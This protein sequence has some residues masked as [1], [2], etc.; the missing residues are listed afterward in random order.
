[1]H[2]KI[3][4]WICPCGCNANS[5]V[6]FYFLILRRAPL[7]QV[8]YLQD[9]LG[10]DIT[11]MPLHCVPI[12]NPP[13][14]PKAKSWF[15]MTLA[16]MSN[17]RIWFSLLYFLAFQLFSLLHRQTKKGI[18]VIS[19]DMY[20]YVPRGR[21]H[22]HVFRLWTERK[23]PNNRSLRGWVFK[24]TAAV[25][26]W[27]RRLGSDKSNPK[28]HCLPT[29]TLGHSCLSGG[30]V[31]SS[32]NLIFVENA[33]ETYRV[34][35]SNRPNQR[36]RFNHRR[37]PL[38]E[39]GS[40][41]VPGDGIRGSLPHARGGAHP[42][43]LRRGPRDRRPSFHRLVGRPAVR[44][45]TGLQALR[46]ELPR[47]R[48]RRRRRNAPGGPR[49]LRPS[50]RLQHRAPRDSRRRTAHPELQHDRRRPPPRQLPI[51]HHAPPVTGRRRKQNRRR[52]I[53]CRRY[54]AGK[55]QRRDHRVRRHHCPLQSPIAGSTR[56]EFEQTQSTSAL[57]NF[58]FQGSSI[59]YSLLS[60]FSVFI[61]SLAY[62]GIFMGYKTLLCVHVI[63]HY[64]TSISVLKI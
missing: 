2:K 3:G 49:H 31:K 50:G 12:Y 40:E 44:Q 30:I 48:R 62:L 51:R 59:H 7:Q 61:D 58:I 24:S 13:F 21:I 60:L 42:D 20:I 4:P 53:F 63:L 15:N 1:M 64:L 25:K 27:R 14:R 52:G 9:S 19:S 32:L 8:A 17:G 26:N 37:N 34:L 41:M 39:R 57:S 47:G 33:F 43:L 46:Q 11:N 55:Y 29:R 23:K 45:P 5:P 22:A 38:P 56:R 28:F 36:L 35:R 10:R 6:L 54:A 18:L 16:F